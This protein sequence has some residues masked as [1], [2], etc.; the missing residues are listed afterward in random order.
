MS[1]DIFKLSSNTDWFVRH[2]EYS[3]HIL[4]SEVESVPGSLLPEIRLTERN[5]MNINHIKRISNEIQQQ[6]VMNIVTELLTDLIAKP[7]KKSVDLNI[8]RSQFHRDKCFQSIKSFNFVMLY[9]RNDYKRY[10][11]HTEFLIKDLKRYKNLNISNPPT[12][13]L[14]I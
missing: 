1:N 5:N 12:G 13:V 3:P 14:P 8:I 11:E 2:R 9:F 4:S 7:V 10:S 6:L